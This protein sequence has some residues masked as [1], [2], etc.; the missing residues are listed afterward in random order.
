MASLVIPNAIQVRLKWMLGT[1]VTAY[2]VLHASTG[3]GTQ[4]TQA[5]ANTI[6]AAIKARYTSSGLALQHTTVTSLN[7]VGLRWIGAANFM[8]FE[9]AGAAVAGTGV[10][11]PLPRAIALVVTLRT[12]MVGKSYRGR[13]YIPGW[14]EGA[15]DGAGLASAAAQT[16]AAAFVN[17]VATDLAA[18][19]YVLGVASRERPADPSA[20]PPVTFKA[21]FITPT[22]TGLVRD[23]LW[24]IQR[25][26]KT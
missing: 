11:D 19:G 22:T 7:K 4:P 25:R 13:V 3:S 6:G 16:A 5:L 10:G 9:D 1:S 8:E 26:R 12:G 21:A 18:S 14:V 23:A 20:V 2:N 24:D 17:G 15:N